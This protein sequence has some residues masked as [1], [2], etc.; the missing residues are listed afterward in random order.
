MDPVL[1]A[2]ITISMSLL[3]AVATMHKIRAPLAFKTAMQ[4][5]RL[6]PSAL[7]NS[8]A[9]LVI[10]AET[11]AAGLALI[12]SV[13]WTGLAIMAGLLFVYA[14]G[15][16]INL[17]R[18]RRNIDCGCNGPASKQMLS[19]WLVVRNLLFL[20]LIL[21]SMQSTTGR[22]FTWLD[23][24]T[25]LFGVLVACGLYLSLNQLLSQAPRV[26]NMRGSI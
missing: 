16:A 15:I 13:R 24:L 6:L 9:L 11:L 7:L 12:P 21:L 25:V 4:E 22:Q 23:S 3:F 10:V 2:I 20:A 19:W 8:A 18:G 17:L 14:A 26:T 1:T 5:Y